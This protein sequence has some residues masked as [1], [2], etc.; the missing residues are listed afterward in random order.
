MKRIVERTMAEASATLEKE[1]AT[2]DQTLAH[3][4]AHCTMAE[5]SATLEKENFRA[6]HP[7]L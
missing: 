4:R 1:K 3:C 5:A 2:F 7:V 6:E